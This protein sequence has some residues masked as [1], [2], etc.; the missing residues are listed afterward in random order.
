MVRP[1]LLKQGDTVAIVAPGKKIMAEDV[2]LARKIFLSW[3]LRVELPDNLFSASHP[4][5]AGADDER[6]QDL[7]WALNNSVVRCIV[8]AR[9]GYGTTRI[10]D[11]LD[12]S[13]LKKDPKW[14]VGF[15]DIT[16]LHLKLSTIGIASIHGTMP[17]MFRKPD[18]ASS[19]ESLKR[20]LLSGNDIIETS[21]SK[22]NRTGVAQGQLIGGNLSLIVDSLGTDSEIDANGKIL[23]IEEIDEYLYKIDRMITQL[24]RA[25]KIERL[26]G[27]IVGHMTGIMDVEGFGES[28]E[29]IIHLAVKDYKFPVA[30]GF[31]SGHVNPN[32][33]WIHG[34]EVALTVT[35]KGSSLS[36]L[37]SDT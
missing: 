4:Y 28:V 7:Q 33:A 14:V 25:G 30:F 5:L 26:S 16:A 23:V 21:Q 3:G 35:S 29:Q 11:K 19:L 27:L 17:V 1:P 18:S 2:E 31:P 8:C 13:A 24:R 9:G 15:S 22:W 37:T 6:I 32:F 20:I 36:L 10:L 12:L 34:A